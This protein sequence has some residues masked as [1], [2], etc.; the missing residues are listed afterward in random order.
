MQSLDFDIDL[1]AAIESD[2]Q[3]L[4]NK[5]MTRGASQQQVCL[6]VISLCVNQMRGAIANDETENVISKLR[7]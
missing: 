6:A 7:N 1:E 4:I 5:A 3:K 2:L